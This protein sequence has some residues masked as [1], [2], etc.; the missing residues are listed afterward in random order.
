MCSSTDRSWKN[1]LEIK[2]ASYVEGRAQIT[3]V[4]KQVSGGNI[5]V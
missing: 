5:G 2:V 4:L 1:Q 3:N